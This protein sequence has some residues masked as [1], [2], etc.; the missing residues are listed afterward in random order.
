MPNTH[1]STHCMLASDQIFVATDRQKSKDRKSVVVGQA[2][3]VPSWWSAQD[4]AVVWTWSQA[5]STTVYPWCQGR[6][7]PFLPTSGDRSSYGAMAQ[8]RDGPI[9]LRDDDDDDDDDEG[10]LHRHPIY[11]YIYGRLASGEW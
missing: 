4:Q 2:N 5:T 11:V 7:D 3:D 10:R 1:Y 9:W 6:L 8:R